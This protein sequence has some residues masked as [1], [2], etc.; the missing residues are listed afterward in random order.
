M[1]YT[2]KNNCTNLCRELQNGTWGT[3][4]TG[5]KK[6]G[7]Q[8]DIYCNPGF[9]L[10]VSPA[11]CKNESNIFDWYPSNATECYGNKI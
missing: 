10:T 5:D 3:V 2:E 11:I 8:L 4:N 6:E 1:T 9:E 7:T